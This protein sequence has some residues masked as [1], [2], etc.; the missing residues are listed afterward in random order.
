MQNSRGDQT[1]DPILVK[2]ARLGSAAVEV[3]LPEGATVYDALNA[4]RFTVGAK[5]QTRLN[6]TKTSA[7]TEVEDGDLITVV[8]ESI[9]GGT[10]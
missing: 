8:Q 6:G 5:E 3:A 2:V 7:G 4:A 10:L 1:S 9:K